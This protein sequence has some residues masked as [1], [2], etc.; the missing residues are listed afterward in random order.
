MATTKIWAVKK[1]MD[2]VIDY[3]T[4]EEKTILTN[5][6]DSL[7]TL[8]NYTT[9]KD[10]TEKQYFVTGINCTP[11]IAVDEMNLTKKQYGKDDKILA[12]HME[13]SFVENEVTPEIA[14]KIGVELATEIWGD[15][16]EVVVSTH[17]NTKHLHNHFVINSVSFADGK[18]YYDNLKNYALI[19]ATSDSL[20]EEYGLSV[21]KEKACPKSKINYENFLKKK[22]ENS[23]YYKDTKQDID[24]AIAQAYSYNDFE[25]ILQKMRYKLTYRAN[26]LS[27][28]REGY[29]RNIRVERAYGEDY[30]INRI[31]ERIMTEKSPRVPFQEAYAR[32]KY[33]A[34]YSYSKMKTISNKY[35]SS[36]YRL[37]LYYCYKLKVFKK[38]DYKEPLTESQREDIRQMNRLSEE[39][40]FLQSR[41]IHTLEELSLYKKSVNT[42]LETLETELYRVNQ[43]LRTTSSDKKDLLENKSEL[44]E[45]IRFLREEMRTCK[46]IK[47]RVPKIK[48]NM[49]DN[50]DEKEREKNERSR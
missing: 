41:K 34:N 10:K 36:I 5:L 39:A 13:Q 26:K 49:K 42:E 8:Y 4:N 9:N 2:M 43:K 11:E 35:R 6:A 22:Y 37:Y 15:R 25:N 21:L 31:T 23:N 32:R 46:S 33:K 38:D 7:N 27:V 29:K 20:C 44:Q 30:T 47:S 28:C 1:R 12:F 3:A 48:E 19:R 16:F 18:K 14:H 45:K 50:Y 40:R 17:L 24:R